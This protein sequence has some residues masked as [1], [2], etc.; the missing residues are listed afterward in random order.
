MAV[1]AGVSQPMIPQREAGAVDPTL[2]RTAL[3]FYYLFQ[4]VFSF[5][6]TPL[7]G[8]VPAEALETTTR[9][10]GLALSGFLVSGTS[11]ISQFASPI[12][13]ENISTNYFWI[14]VGWD[15]IESVC[16]YFFAYVPIHICY[17]FLDNLGLLMIPVSSP[18]VGHLRNSSTST[19]SQTPLRHLSAAT[20]LLC[21][22][23]GTLL[24]RSPRTMR[25]GRLVPYL[26]CLV[27]LWN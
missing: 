25:K 12:A 5:T 27:C 17:I 7:Q 21:S 4:V 16:W 13:L 3:S 14:F 1:N 8:V 18:K 19:S 23:M 15:V 22:R 2:G 20:R 6:Y 24:R 11:F 26:T 9:A 10:K